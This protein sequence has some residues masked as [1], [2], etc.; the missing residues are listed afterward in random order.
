MEQYFFIPKMAEEHVAGDFDDE[1][2]LAGAAGAVRRAVAGPGKPSAGAALGQSLLLEDQPVMPPFLL[3]PPHTYGQAL[4]FLP[5]E[6][7]RSA[8]LA[9]R[10]I[11][12]EA[13]RGVQ[14]IH[15]TKPAHPVARHLHH[16]ADLNGPRRFPNLKVVN[17]AAMLRPSF[18]NNVLSPETAQML[19]FPAFQSLVPKLHLGQ[20]VLAADYEKDYVETLLY[21]L[22]QYGN[23]TT[24]A[25]PG[26]FGGCPVVAGVSTFNLS[27]TSHFSIEFDL[28]RLCAVGLKHYGT[29]MIPNAKG[30]VLIVD[31]NDG[32]FMIG[33]QRLYNGVIRH[34]C[35]AIPVVVVAPY[36][37]DAKKNELFDYRRIR[38]AMLKNFSRHAAPY[39]F[40]AVSMDRKESASR[41]VFHLL[42]KLLG[43]GD[44]YMQES[45]Y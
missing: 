5:Y 4:E 33:V 37:T 8:M 17:L 24:K 26:R 7:V 13:A 27:T 11:R 36:A 30:A 45:S 31:P 43:L 2:D 15:V 40:F 35:G 29:P 39:A 14:V 32:G 6:D 3:V 12:N 18:G 21:H 22:K 20:I 38:P 10:A 9:A 23:V 25:G 28:I 44:F 1:T 41:P 42:H 19:L 16:G 34:G